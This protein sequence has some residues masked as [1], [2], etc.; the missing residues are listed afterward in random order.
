MAYRGG[1]QFPVVPLGI[2][3]GLFA[4]DGVLASSDV[5]AGRT[6]YGMF[7]SP[8]SG[9]TGPTAWP[10]SLMLQA[11]AAAAGLAGELWLNWSTDISDPLLTYAVGA[12]AREFAFKTAQGSSGTAVAQGYRAMARPLSRPMAARGFNQWGDTYPV[13]S[14]A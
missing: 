14:V 12:A 9:A 4:A 1:R 11:A 8:P 13:G 3:A 10:R 5:N 2:S 6:R 7:G